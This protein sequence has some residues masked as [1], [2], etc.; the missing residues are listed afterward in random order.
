MVN[1]IC[2]DKSGS[3]HGDPGIGVDAT[4]RLSLGKLSSSM[5]TLKGSSWTQTHTQT[6]RKDILA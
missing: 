6:N 2:A 4:G 3:Y 5:L 1:H